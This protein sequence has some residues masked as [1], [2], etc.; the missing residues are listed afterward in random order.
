MHRQA[1]HKRPLVQVVGLLKTFYSLLESQGN[2][3]YKQESQRVYVKS[4]KTKQKL[5]AQVSSAS[6]FIAD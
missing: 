5:P 1:E 6:M 3:Y 4:K 2:K